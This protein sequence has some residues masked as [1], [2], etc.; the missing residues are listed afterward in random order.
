MP[1]QEASPRRELSEREAE[2]AEL[3]ASGDTYKAIAR[4]LNIAPAT[5]RKHIG[6]IYHKLGVVN[7]I[8]LLREIGG[9][10]PAS[11]EQQCAIAASEKAP[12]WAERRALA[13]VVLEVDPT[14]ASDPERMHE[15]LQMFQRLIDDITARF[16]GT[17]AARL[18]GLAVACFG[19]PEAHDDDAERAVRAGMEMLE[20]AA[21]LSAEQLDARAAAAFGTVIADPSFGGEVSGDALR[22][23]RRMA[24]SGEAGRLLIDAGTAALVRHAFQ[25]AP[26]G[27]AS[28]GGA[29]SFLVGSAIDSPTRFDARTSGMVAPFVGRQAELALLADRWRRA[30]VGEGQA[31]LIRG[32]PGIGKSRLVREFIESNDLSS[33]ADVIQSLPFHTNT[34]LHPFVAHLESVTRTPS[35]SNIGWMNHD[36]AHDLL[37]DLVRGAESAD[38]QMWSARDRRARALRLYARLLL[39]PAPEGPRLLVIEDIHWLDPSSLELLAFMLELHVGMSTL[40]L[41]TAREH[42]VQSLEGTAGMAAVTLG[43]LHAADGHLLVSGVAENGLDAATLAEIVERSGGIPLFMEELAQSIAEL[44]AAVP[45][46][47]PVERLHRVR[48]VPLTLQ[49]T[50]AMRLERLGAARRTAQAAAVIGRTFDKPLLRA[51]SRAPRAKLDEDWQ[52]LATSSLFRQVDEGG[53]PAL[54]FKHALVRDAAYESLLL[55]ERRSLHAR[56]THIYRKTDFRAQDSLI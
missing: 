1:D 42:P 17:V 32:E 26:V 27:A 47:P 55:G 39:S 40:L 4:T 52:R 43:P 10:E 34:P 36:E 56:L 24:A 22:R 5:V 46:D 2:V 23:A 37:Q 44:P 9:H 53:K 20:G 13:V 49:Q 35:R 11:P 48:P 41:L 38:H 19:W 28:A 12:G 15:A 51:L 31:V 16:G 7:K 3:Y 25:L 50:I 45:A 14:N 29:P 18:D 21:S 33:G 6:S 8:E 30:E 54:Q